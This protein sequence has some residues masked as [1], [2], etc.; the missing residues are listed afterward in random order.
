MFYL[1]WWNQRTHSPVKFSSKFFVKYLKC[2][3]NIPVTGLCSQKKGDMDPCVGLKLRWVRNMDH[4][5]IFSGSRFQLC[6]VW[7]FQLLMLSMSILI[8]FW[9]FLKGDVWVI[10]SG[11]SNVMCQFS[12]C[13]L[14]WRDLFHSL[15]FT[16]T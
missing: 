7:Y 15:I 10:V 16:V 1:Y 3:H 11:L 6:W 5:E 12:M 14:S 8:F 2:F 13:I 4:F 9:K